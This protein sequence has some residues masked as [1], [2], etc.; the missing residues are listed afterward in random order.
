M[1]THELESKVR[2]LR[3]LQALIEEATAEAEAIKDAIKA[4]MGDSEELLAGEYK[5]TWKAVNASRIDTTALRKALPD[6]AERFTRIT[7]TR[8]FCVA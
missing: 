1:S 2:E 7:T 6:V 3:Q 5:I 8:R 4:S